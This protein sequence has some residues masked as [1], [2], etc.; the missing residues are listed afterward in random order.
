MAISAAGPATAPTGSAVEAGATVIAITDSTRA[1]I[2]KLAQHLFV[3]STRGQAFPESVTGALAVA[4]L[5]VSLVVVRMG[6]V[7]LDRI[8]DNERR[9][10]ATGEYVL[11]RRGRKRS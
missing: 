8:R 2:A 10:V 9:I 3:T 4:N 6:N 7:A 5:L 11:V 1:P